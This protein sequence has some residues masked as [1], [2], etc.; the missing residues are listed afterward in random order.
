MFKVKLENKLRD[1]KK[2]EAARYE[3]ASLKEIREERKKSNKI[4]ML[5]RFPAPREG[6]VGNV[7]VDGSLL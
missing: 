1:A 6:F 5:S 3:E 4:K 7:N 2:E